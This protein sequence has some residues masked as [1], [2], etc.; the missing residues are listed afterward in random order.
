[1]AMRDD[2]GV[3]GSLRLDALSPTDAY[4][5][6]LRDQ[7]SM[8][9]ALA[10]A[11]AHVKALRRPPEQLTFWTIIQA[12]D[13]DPGERIT[14]LARSVAIEHRGLGSNSLL[15][16]E[17]GDIDPFVISVWPQP[18][19]A[20]HLVATV[21]ASD[22]RWQRVERWVMNASPGLTACYL[23][24]GDFLTIGEA[25]SKFGTVEVGK[26]TWRQANQSHAVG[27]REAKP[28]LYEAVSRDVPSTGQVRTAL[29]RAGDLSVHLRRLAGATLYAGSLKAFEATVLRRLERAARERLA[30]LRNR[31]RSGTTPVRP[32]R[33]S[34]RE[35]LLRTPED[36]GIVIDIL[37]EEP[38]LAVAVIHRNPY[39]HLAVSDYDDGSNFDVFVTDPSEV[40]VHPGFTASVGSLNRVL[41]RLSES[42]PS[43]EVGDRADRPEV[44]VEDLL[45]PIGP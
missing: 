34:L 9:D 22:R 37:R 41:Q 43:E 11:R 5:W 45:T 25:L 13:Q 31:A 19:G 33:V 32:L 8:V 3:T 44:T 18:D 2:A 14:A 35:P 27:Y 12:S 17:T 4:L 36:T 30:L 38:H 15:A 26:L 39:L 20:V 28:T 16:V 23:N 21:P 40:V 6:G 42:L 7:R 24:E 29:M 10:D 1:M